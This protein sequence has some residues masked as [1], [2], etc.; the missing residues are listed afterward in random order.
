MF[1]SV[2][3]KAKDLIYKPYVARIYIEGDVDHSVTHSV[4]KTLEKLRVHNL[5]AIAL[6]VNSKGG[7]A[8]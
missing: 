3:N 5:K 8:A 4:C 6:T 2:A 7:S 1:R